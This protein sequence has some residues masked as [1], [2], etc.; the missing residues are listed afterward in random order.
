MR[1]IFLFIILIISQFALYAQNDRIIEDLIE[2]IAANSEQ[3]VDFSTIYDD[4]NYYLENPLNLNTATRGQLRRLHFLNDL[5]IDDILNY[6]KK[7]GDFETIYELQ[8]LPNFTDEDIR[9]LLPFVYVGKAQKSDTLLLKHAIEYGRQQLFLRTK[10]I[11]QP[12]KGYNIPDSVLDENPNKAHYLGS[13]YKLYTRYKFQYRDRIQAGITAEK[14]A[15]EQFF[16]GAQKYGFDFYSAHIQ[17]NNIWKFKRIVIGD[18]Q[19]QF[20]EGLVLW[21]GISFGKSALVL[22][23]KKK[24]Q[25]IRKYS[26]T[27][28]N[29]FMRG[30]GFTIKYHNLEVSSFFSH[31]KVDG[32]ISLIDTAEGENNVLQITSLQIT[33]Y[34]RTPSEIADKH[35]VSQ[36]LWGGNITYRGSFYKLGLTAV[37]YNINADLIRIPKPYQIYQFQGRKNFNAGINYTFYIKKLI[38]FGEAAI[39]KNF[40]KAIISGIIAPLAPRVSSVILY[41]NYSQDYQAY[42]SNAFA[43]GTRT[44]NEQGVYWGMEILPYQRFKLSSYFDFYKF[45]WLRFRVN[46]PETYGTDYLLQLDYTPTRYIS[47]YLRFKKEIKEQNIATEAFVK[48]PLNTEKW[49]LRY[50]ITWNLDNGIILKNRIELTHYYKEH[51]KNEYGFMA[52]Q[53]IRYKPSFIPITLYFRYAVFDAPYDARIYAYENDVLYAF[54]VPGYFYQGYRTYLMLKYDITRRLTLWAR[55]AQTTY[56]DRDIISK[57]SLNEIDG[58]TKSEIKLQLRY[59]F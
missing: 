43:E 32:N 7:Y 48:Y 27:D 35:S 44:Q 4:L 52:Y 24:P 55:Y 41:R 50:H 8:L 57:G 6:R 25:G 39:S 14:D 10:F 30:A 12:Q 58:N 51:E 15:G 20:G 37:S 36:T 46:A 2:D 56:T 3:E 26:S 16:R 54:S 21:T 11:L 53:D 45:P 33:G 42:F 31:H 9:H 1:R 5:Q 22:N 59:K 49:Q 28:E 29:R 13:P 18:Y 34:H 40:G 23:V 17:L 19:L 47:M 38:L